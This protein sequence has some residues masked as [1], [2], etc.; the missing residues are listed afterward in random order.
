MEQG[1][2]ASFFLARETPTCTASLL[3]LMSV[4]TT[5]IRRISFISPSIKK[6]DVP[7][8]NTDAALPGMFTGILMCTAARSMPVPEFAGSDILF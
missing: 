3:C 4:A 5:M 8:R 2:P 7:P 6:L 1:N